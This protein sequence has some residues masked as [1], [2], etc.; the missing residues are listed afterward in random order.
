MLSCDQL[1]REIICC[2]LFHIVGLDKWQPVLVAIFGLRMMVWAILRQ[3]DREENVLRVQ[4]VRTESVSMKKRGVPSKREVLIVIVGP[5]MRIHML[6][7]YLFEV[8]P[9]IPMDPDEYRKHLSELVPRYILQFGFIPRETFRQF[10][11]SLRAPNRKGIVLAYEFL[12]SL[13][14]RTASF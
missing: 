6:Q 4:E 1:S 3:Y 10:L 7:K 11:Y 14:S 8:I 13:M 2:T 5:S 12:P 9:V